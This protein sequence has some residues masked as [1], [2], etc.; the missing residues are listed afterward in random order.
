LFGIFYARRLHFGAV[1]HYEAED[2]TLSSA[3]RV[4]RW[5]RTG[6][7]STKSPHGCGE[8]DP[9]ETGRTVDP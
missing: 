1:L 2:A 5:A 7:G 4:P 6:T 9:A 3:R 8:P